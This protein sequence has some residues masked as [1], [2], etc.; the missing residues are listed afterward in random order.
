MNF[1]GA[2]HLH[3]M[4]VSILG[5]KNDLQSFITGL[6]IVINGPGLPSE[7]YCLERINLDHGVVPD[8]GWNLAS[9]GAQFHFHGLVDGAGSVKFILQV[10]NII[11]PGAKLGFQLVIG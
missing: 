7:R 1:Q 2:R 3:G 10:G 8:S 11:I 6:A 4:V 5:F 9:L